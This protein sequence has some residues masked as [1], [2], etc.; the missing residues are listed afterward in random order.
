MRQIK[1]SK[2]II[3]K[4]QI[5]GEVPV[6]N[7]KLS[8]LHPL[9]Y[10]DQPIARHT[11]S[12]H[13]HGSHFMN[14]PHVS[15]SPEGSRPYQVGDPVRLIDWKA[16]ARNDQLL[17]R[18]EHDEA[19]VQ[20]S[21][22]ID[23]R[24][25]MHWPEK[26]FLK[27]LGRDSVPKFSTAV[28]IALHL[29]YR[30]LKLGDRVHLALITEE[31]LKERSYLLNF[32]NAD[33]VLSLFQDL[34]KTFKIESL[35]SYMQEQD[36]SFSSKLS[37]WVGDCF[38]GSPPVEFLQDSK[39]SILF[40]TLSFLEYDLSWMQEKTCYYDDKAIL[41]ETLGKE[42]KSPDV[43]AEKLQTWSSSLEKIMRKHFG[44]YFLVHEDVRIQKYM[45]YLDTISK[46][47]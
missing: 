24:D 21:I 34:E 3:V 11:R 30:H 16:F 20:V 9:H 40:H 42:I 7:T 2:D 28:R 47:G 44:Y 8:A 13:I 45:S 38:S 31:N 23:G 27:N 43:Y 36:L 46:Y 4:N 10:T 15:K 6:E 1:S 26:T 22:A 37:Y 18:E 17:V 29:V 33:E 32:R 5:G 41:R 19:M 35:K 12:P 14:I 25:S 39:R